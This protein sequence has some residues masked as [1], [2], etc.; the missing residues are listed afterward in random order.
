[1]KNFKLAQIVLVIVI[2]VM[3]LIMSTNVKAADYD[4]LA[5]AV[6]NSSSNSSN[7]AGSSNSSGN[8][9]SNNTSNNSSTSN[10][11]NNTLN[12]SSLR[13]SANTTGATKNTSYNNTNL[14]TTGIVDSLPVVVLIVIFGISTVYAYKKI[15]D[16][17]SL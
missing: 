13:N 4:D 10:S 16:Y 12:T 6:T 7:S 15:K 3:L 1:M 2:G 17:R 14:P 11:T 9:I 8:S 5:A